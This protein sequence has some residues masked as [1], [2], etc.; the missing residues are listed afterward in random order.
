MEEKIKRLRNKIKRKYKIITCVL[1]FIIS[2]FAD[3]IFYNKVGNYPKEEYKR[4]EEYVI[5]TNAD[6]MFY[7]KLQDENIKILHKEELPKKRR[8]SLFDKK[9]LLVYNIMV[10][11]I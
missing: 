9:S 3:S 6:D 2:F 1:V 4:L 11:K 5:K 8:L 10:E 7:T